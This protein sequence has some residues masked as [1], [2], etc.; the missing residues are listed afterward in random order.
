[1]LW[2]F[3]GSIFRSVMKTSP[4]EKIPENV[5]EIK[6]SKIQKHGRLCLQQVK[7][8]RTMTQPLGPFPPAH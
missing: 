4:E 1:M 2:E 8:H 5:K 3:L 6:L 7:C